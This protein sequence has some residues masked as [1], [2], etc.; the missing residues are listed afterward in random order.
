MGINILQDPAIPLLGIYPKDAQSYHKD[1][2][3]TMFIVALFVIARIWKQPRCPLMEEWI[4]K[5]WYIYSV[6]KYSAVKNND[7]RKF[8][9]KWIE[10]E[11]VILEAGEMAQ[12]CSSRGPEFNSQQP[13]VSSQPTIIRPGTL[14]SPA[15]IY[16]GRTLYA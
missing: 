14:F 13:H 12:L 4:K 6:E 15:G 16:A 3:S 8:E 5:T 7:I 11:K 9:G 2:C 1:I 10:L